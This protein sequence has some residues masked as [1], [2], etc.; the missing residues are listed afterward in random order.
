MPR[1]IAIIDSDATTRQTLRSLLG[2]LNIDVRVYDTA[3]SYLARAAENKPLVCL[4]VDIA[5]PGISGL[6]LLKQ[7]RASDTKLPVILL[8]SEADVT[9]AVAAMRHGATDFIEKSQ[10]DVALLKRVSQLLRQ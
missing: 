10:L 7:I 1:S 9:M 4:I 3:E 6:Q 5:L 8:A 2:N